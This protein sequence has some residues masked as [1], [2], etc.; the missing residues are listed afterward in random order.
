MK[1]AIRALVLPYWIAFTVGAFLFIALMIA[2][3][4]ITEHVRFRL[5]RW[6]V[7]SFARLDREAI[8]W[9]SLVFGWPPRDKERAA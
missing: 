2:W 8:W 4:S 3:L 7:D 5:P 6:F 9:D 1:Y